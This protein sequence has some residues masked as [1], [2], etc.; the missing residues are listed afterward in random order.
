MGSFTIN[1]NAYCILYPRFSMT[2][3][4]QTSINP[5]TIRVGGCFYLSFIVNRLFLIASLQINKAKLF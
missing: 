2:N 4:L 3:I 1:G 5:I